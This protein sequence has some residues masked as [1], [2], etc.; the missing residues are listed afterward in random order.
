M[1]SKDLT[2]ALFAFFIIGILFLLGSFVCTIE[3]ASY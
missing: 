2:G 1:V 3:L